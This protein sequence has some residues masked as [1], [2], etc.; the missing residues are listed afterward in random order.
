M[1]SCTLLH[2]ETNRY[3]R[4]QRTSPQAEGDLC[5]G[6][7]NNETGR[8]EAPRRVCWEG[9]KE[10]VYSPSETKQIIC[11]ETDGQTVRSCL[12]ILTIHPAWRIHG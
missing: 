10:E 1:S 4:S 5:I 12:P 7:E 2:Y 6:R 9:G 11:M 8:T 3:G